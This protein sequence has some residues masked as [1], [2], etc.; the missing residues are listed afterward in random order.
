MSGVDTDEADDID[1]TDDDEFT[2]TQERGKPDEVND[3]S[4]DDEFTVPRKRR[5]TRLV[6]SI[7]SCVTRFRLQI[8]RRVFRSRYGFC[9]HSSKQI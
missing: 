7:L 4:D 5:K 6:L 2:I 9:K 8:F 1:V 3:T